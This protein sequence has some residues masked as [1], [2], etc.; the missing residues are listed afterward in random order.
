MI[1]EA[2]SVLGNVRIRN[3]KR[4]Y[5]QTSELLEDRKE[6][7]DAV[8]MQKREREKL[9][10]EVTLRSAAVG[11]LSQKLKVKILK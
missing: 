8:A 11:A 6:L 3:I 1:N 2:D 9:C 5:F 10:K 4:F 7:L